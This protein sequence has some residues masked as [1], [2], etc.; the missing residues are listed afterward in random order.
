MEKEL[1]EKA[2]N[3][4]LHGSTKI[5]SSTDS[6]GNVTSNEIIINDLR[7]QLVSRLAEQLVKTEEFK[8]ALLNV[9]TA[10]VIKKMQDMAIAT[11]KF[12]D[13][14]YS[15]QNKIKSKISTDVEIRQLKIV[16]DVITKE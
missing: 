15:V 3:S 13:L 5:V 6:Y 2:L 10:D 8:K 4:I 16:A 1:L 11:V 7:V 14:D 12:G 9:F